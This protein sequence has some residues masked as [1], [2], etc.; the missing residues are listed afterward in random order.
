MR[1]VGFFVPVIAA[2]A[3]F[4]ILF[5]EFSDVRSFPTNLSQDSTTDAFLVVDVGLLKADEGVVCPLGLDIARNGQSVIFDSAG[6][7]VAS[8]GL[9]RSTPVGLRELELRNGEIATAFAAIGS[10]AFVATQYETGQPGRLIYVDAG[11]VSAPKPSWTQAEPKFKLL[12]VDAGALATGSTGSAFL[13]IADFEPSIERQIL[14]NGFI[15]ISDERGR[16]VSVDWE[17]DSAYGLALTTTFDD[18]ASRQSF[19]VSDHKIE[20]LRGLGLDTRGRAYLLVTETVP[21][22]TEIR[23]EQTVIR[24]DQSSD[25]GIAFFFV[26]RSPLCTPT[27]NVAISADGDVFSLQLL[28]DEVVITKLHVKPAWYSNIRWGARWLPNR[29]GRS[30]SHSPRKVAEQATAESQAQSIAE[31]P[32][33]FSEIEGRSIAPDIQ[34]VPETERLESSRRR[35]AAMKSLLRESFVRQSTQQGVTRRDVIA[36]ACTY[37]HLPWKMPE[38]S[39]SPSTD[40]C[41]D[42][43]A[44]SDKCEDSDRCSLPYWSRPKR[45]KSYTDELLV[46]LPYAWAGADWPWEFIDKIEAGRPA[47]DVC[48]EMIIRERT[49]SINDVYSAGLDCS[50]FVQRAWGWEGV[51]YSTRSL[52]SI[53]DPIDKEA[54]RP[55]DV[56]NKPGSHVRMFLRWT[57]PSTIE[58]IESSTFCGGICRRTLPWDTFDGYIPMRPRHLIPDEAITSGEVDELCSAPA[59]MFREFAE[60]NR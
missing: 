23:L 48:T 30:G 50:G 16:F 33:E 21:H 57:S 15:S 51:R 38:R 5:N 52:G 41:F 4:T 7:R 11:A 3:Y 54:L 32:A 59:A 49:N 55:G 17:S 24:L 60:S 25:K 10:G 34:A 19:F 45:F 1:I 9:N 37:L 13:R 14:S 31:P 46:S 2:L 27:Q 40:F 22:P 20:S 18:D 12:G 36:N 39:Y 47:G 29:F 28:R 26:P 35:I 8:F 44:F 42:S 58:F 6:D 43:R 56:L 53:A